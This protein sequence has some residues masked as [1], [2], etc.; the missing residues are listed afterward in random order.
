VLKR[1][2]LVLIILV[3]VK[4]AWAIEMIVDKP[5]GG[6]KGLVVIAPAKKYLM[7][8]RL[9]SE[10]ASR[11]KAAGYVA[12][13]FNWSQDTL[14]TPELE[15]SRAARDIQYVVRTA[16]YHLGFQPARTVLISK[17]FSTKAI[18][19]S[20]SLARMHVA[21]T[22]NCSTEAPFG[23]TYAHVLARKDIVLRMIISKDD[24]YCNVD[25]IRQTLR[26]ISRLPLLGITPHGDHNFMVMKGAVSDYFYQDQVVRNVLAQIELSRLELAP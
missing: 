14:Q 4:N 19:P 12:V 10:L 17:S 21:L 24:P 7:K 5:S 20:L 25:E 23:A 3:L 9:F 22:P 8:E 6:A 11:L 16:Q 13:R 18:G 15:L 2:S 1:Y 26:Q